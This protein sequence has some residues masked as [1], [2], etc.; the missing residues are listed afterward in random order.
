MNYKLLKSRNKSLYRREL[1]L[2][3]TIAGFILLITGVGITLK[4]ILLTSPIGTVT[5]EAIILV[6]M[7]LIVIGVIAISY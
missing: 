6:G 1:F 7:I 3:K 4:G 5:W 2:S